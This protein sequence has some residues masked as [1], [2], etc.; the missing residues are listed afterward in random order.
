MAPK[1]KSFN[2]GL[3]LLGLQLGGTW[4]PDDNER[5]AAWEMYVELVTRISVVELRQEEGLLREG[6]TSLY[7]L[8][9]TTRGILREYGPSVAQ[10]RDGGDMS[11]GHMAVAVLNHVLRPV[12]AKWHPLLEDYEAGRRPSVSR[13]E[14]ER[15]W[16]RNAELR[17]ALAEVRT[18]LDEY[19][20]MLARAAGV[21]WL[22]AKRPRRSRSRALR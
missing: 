15:R 12:L 8:F 18:A 16:E 3:N 14:H 1:L 5:K 22:L 2:V 21:P 13:L 17:Q 4:V 20:K 19:A 9:E 10:P 11:F 7:S 6:L